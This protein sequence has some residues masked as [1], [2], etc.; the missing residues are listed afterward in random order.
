MIEGINHTSF[1][2][3]APEDT[4]IGRGYRDFRN[5]RS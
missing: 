3:V 4:A 5:G 1:Y 2:I